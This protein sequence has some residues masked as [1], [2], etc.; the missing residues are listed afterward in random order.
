[1]S[2]APVYLDSES[3]LYDNYNSP[4]S[5]FPVIKVVKSFDWLG[6]YLD[7]FVKY[8]RSQARANGTYEDEEWPRPWKPR[9]LD[10]LLNI[11]LVFMGAR[12]SCII[13][14]GKEYNTVLIKR[15]NSLIKTLDYAQFSLATCSSANLG[16]GCRFVYRLDNPRFYRRYHLSVREQGQN[17]D[18]F[19]AGH[20]G[21]PAMAY[22]EDFDNTS[23]LMVFERKYQTNILS[24]KIIYHFLSEKDQLRLKTFTTK[25]VDLINRALRELNL[26]FEFVYTF[27]SKALHQE[28]L[29]M[30]SHEEPPPLDWWNEHWPTLSHESSYK[31]TSA[32]FPHYPSI[33]KDRSMWP[34]IR[35]HHQVNEDNT[36]FCQTRHGYLQAL[37]KEYYIADRAL[38][39]GESPTKVASDLQDRACILEA[40]R[41]SFP[42]FTQRIYTARYR[43]Y[44]H[45]KRGVRRVAR[46]LYHEVPRALFKPECRM[47]KEPTVRQYEPVTAPKLAY[48]HWIWKAN[49]NVKH[50][51]KKDTSLEF[52]WKRAFRWIICNPTEAQM[53][54]SGEWNV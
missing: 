35:V 42:P 41:D 30:L 2:V 16:S 11:I 19:C 12:T 3:V 10:D 39:R 21:A 45:I 4:G 52:S 1:M 50:T 31:H 40:K 23:I 36:V 5:K 6:S 33:Y 13:D 48:K 7:D 44:I 14:H 9:G 20:G 15:I 24:E 18:Y 29:N 51:D 34:V 47:V 25:K 28:R 38:E 27:N 49:F 17:L 37:W 32:N 26:D 46:V 54:S 22:A 8:A 43:G 53:L